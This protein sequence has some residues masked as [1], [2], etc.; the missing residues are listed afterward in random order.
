LS[1][2]DDAIQEVRTL[3]ET[4]ANDSEKSSAYI[5]QLAWLFF[6][7]CQPSSQTCE[8][9]RAFCQK[10][11]GFHYEEQPDES[12]VAFIEQLRNCI[13]R[14]KNVPSPLT[15]T[16][17]TISIFYGSLLTLL[18][19]LHPHNGFFDTPA[20]VVHFMVEA[21]KP[22]AGEIIYDPAA[23]ACGLL[24]E[25]YSQGN[26]SRTAFQG[27]EIDPDVAMLGAINMALHGIDI[28]KFHRQDALSVEISSQD[29]SNTR[30]TQPGLFPDEELERIGFSIKPVDVILTHLPFDRHELASARPQKGTKQLNLDYDGYFLKHC[31]QSL[32]EGEK[33]RCALIVEREIL[34]GRTKDH[35]Q[36]RQELFSECNIQM[37]ITLPPDTFGEASS[38]PTFLLFFSSGQGTQ[39]TLRYELPL[40]KGTAKGTD[41]AP[42]LAA[43][44]QW[45][46]HLAGNGP[47]PEQN[48][49]LWIECY[50][51]LHYEESLLKDP[52]YGPSKDPYS[53]IRPQPGSAPALIE[54]KI[55]VKQ[56]LEQT[57]ELRKAAQK[58]QDL[59][60]QGEE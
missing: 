11:C 21:L 34:S 3:L 46:D 59:L 25:A 35:K 6:L 12:E 40:E 5:K 16:A 22:E 52:D 23:G 50:D 19:E 32:K 29:T 1:T 26:I 28:A 17:D 45:C 7:R 8:N 43:W 55:L 47:P 13:G 60:E 30:N 38:Q 9:V 20:P 31:M 51:A 44:Q 15:G 39:K 49:N 36:L 14:I 57:E 4:C 58:L 56:L 42:V 2:L 24:V 37:I 27:F 53:L 10:Q 54:P 18:A 41:F 48:K 33:S